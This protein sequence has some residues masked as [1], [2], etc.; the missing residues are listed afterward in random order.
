FLGLGGATKWVGLYGAF[1][2]AVLFFMSR[3]FEYMDYNRWL[4]KAVEQNQISSNDRPKLRRSYIL[5]YW[6][7]TCLFCVLFFIIIPAAIYT[8]SFIPIQNHNDDRNLVVEVIDS[9]KSMYNYHK[10]VVEPHP[11]SSHWYE[12]PLMLRPIYY[13]AGQL[14]PEGLG[15]SIAAFGNPMVWWT[16]FIAFWVLLWLVVSRRFGKTLG[17]TE[18]RNAWFPVI[19]YLSLYL[20]WAVAPRKL[21]FIYH[22]FSCVPFLILMLA[23]VLRYLERTNLIKRRFVSILM[24]SVLVLFVLYY[25]VLSGLIVPRWYLNALR[26]LPR[27]AW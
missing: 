10:G 26:I 14:L 12:W 23:M 17:T 6:M 8:L 4:D 15:S 13:Y 11:Y 2:L 20:P 18:T 19:G 24:I 21:T 22:Y 27:W 16:G 3:I 9:V 25:P 5:K 7:G 1:G